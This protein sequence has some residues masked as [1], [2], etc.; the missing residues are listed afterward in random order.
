MADSVQSAGD[1]RWASSVVGATI[2]RGGML[3]MENQRRAA[4][5]RLG[6]NE[7]TRVT[8]PEARIRAE[9]RNPSSSN[10]NDETRNPNR[11]R[12]PGPEP[13][14]ANPDPSS[15]HLPI[16][17]DPPRLSRIVRVTRA[18][19][20]R[21]NLLLKTTYAFSGLL[22]H[23][24]QR[25]T[26]AP[27]A[28]AAP[29]G[30]IVVGRGG[31]CR[32]MG[33]GDGEESTRPTKTL[34]MRPRGPVRASGRYCRRPAPWPGPASTRS[35]QALPCGDRLH[36]RLTATVSRRGRSPMSDLS[37]FPTGRPWVS[38]ANRSCDRSSRTH[39]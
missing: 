35:A 11:I 7:G 25:S 8:K 16:P 29:R 13:R 6:G 34:A 12:N 5:C 3:V 30:A 27:L 33:I 38:L 20:V 1:A 24:A 19:Y 28:A 37:G 18:P 32:T 15:Q 17:P 31:R 9:P 39:S 22:C 2:A 21:A 23:V 10:A 4:K 36:R 26:A 14:S